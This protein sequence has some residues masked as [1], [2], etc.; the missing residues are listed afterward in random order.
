MATTAPGAVVIARADVLPLTYGDL[1]KAVTACPECSSYPR[2]LPEESGAIY[3]SSQPVRDWQIDY[4]DLLFLSEGS[5]YALVCVHSEPALTQAFSCHCGNQAA[6]I[7]E[8]ERLSTTYGYSHHIDSDQ[9]LHF[10]VMLCKT[11]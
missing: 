8:L 1:A 4:F 3:Q 2:Q 5:E 9:G 7:R 6:S 11:G 10:K